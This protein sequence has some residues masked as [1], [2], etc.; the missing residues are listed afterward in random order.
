MSTQMNQAKKGNAFGIVSFVFGFIGIFIL[1]IVL[2]PV[3]IL[4]GV[5]GIIKKQY[6]WSGVGIICAI[7]GLLTSPMFLTIIGVS[8]VAAGAR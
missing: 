2:C 5:I 6:I 7:I 4:F 3:S 1:S 8:S